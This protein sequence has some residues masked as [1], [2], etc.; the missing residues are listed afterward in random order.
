MRAF[1]HLKFTALFLL[2]MTPLGFSQ[3]KKLFLVLESNLSRPEDNFI[4]VQL[5]YAK[6][7]LPTRDRNKE[8][9]EGQAIPPL[10]L[11]Y[12][13]ALPPYLK[14]LK[15]SATHELVGAMCANPDAWVGLKD[16]RSLD[17][18]RGTVAVS[19][20]LRI[21]RE[22]LGNYS[23]QVYV[24]GY[25]IKCQSCASAEAAIWEHPALTPSSYARRAMVIDAED[26]R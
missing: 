23:Y 13:N 12:K 26:Y 4:G 25:K 7:Y 6:G 21:P 18:Q 16:P 14:E 11:E 15:L 20:L 17:L 1:Q 3:E 9:F 19:Q 5:Y 8:I 24:N 22:L 2:V 10:E